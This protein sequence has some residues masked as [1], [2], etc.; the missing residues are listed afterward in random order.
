MIKTINLF[1]FGTK[2]STAKRGS[3]HCVPIIIT[4]DGCV[5]GGA[6][7]TILPAVLIKV[8]PEKR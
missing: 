8:L 2:R 5:L 4:G 1:S 7:G 6:A 3:M